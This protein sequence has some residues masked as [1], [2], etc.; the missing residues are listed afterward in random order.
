MCNELVISTNA[1]F[2]LANFN[3]LGVYFEKN[4]PDKNKVNLKYPNVYRLAT[5]APKN[6]SCFFRYW[7]DGL[8]GDF[9][10]DFKTCKNGLMKILMMAILSIPDFYFK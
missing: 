5:Y 10:G 2:D 4:V 1:P 6:C 8:I 3:T 7:Q 9:R